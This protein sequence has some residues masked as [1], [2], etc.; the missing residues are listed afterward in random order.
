MNFIL[1]LLNKKLVVFFDKFKVS[2]PKIAILIYVVIAAIVKGAD[3]I[4]SLPEISLF[5]GG[6]L[7]IVKTFVYGLGLLF[8]A[9]TAPHTSEAVKE[10]NKTDSLPEP[11]A[12][13]EYIPETGSINDILKTSAN[14]TNFVDNTFGITTT[15][16]TALVPALDIKEEPVPVKNPKKIYYPSNKNGKSTKK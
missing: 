12:P 11:E 13:V 8:T 2:N 10:I 7:G 6:S 9:L 14:S 15:T 3:T 16:A 1:K 4:L 5:L